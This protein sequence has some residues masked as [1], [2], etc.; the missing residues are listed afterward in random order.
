[1]VT[2]ADHANWQ[3]D[4]LQPYIEHVLGAFG[5]DRLMFGSDA[6]V[7][8]LATTYARWVETLADATKHLSAADKEKLWRTNAKEFYRI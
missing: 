7:A 8:Y 6:P 5:I 1:M 3:P 2:E 4:D